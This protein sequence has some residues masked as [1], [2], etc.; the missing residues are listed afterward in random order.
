MRQRGRGVGMV[1]KL[2]ETIAKICIA[3][4]LG[5][6]VGWCLISAMPHLVN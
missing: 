3:V 1:N 6:M 5:G 2:S 4:A